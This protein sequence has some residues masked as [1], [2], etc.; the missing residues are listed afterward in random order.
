MITDKP[1]GE[2]AGHRVSTVRYDELAV[3]IYDNRELMGRAT[4]TM[5]CERIN[6]LF[7]QQGFVNIIFAAAPS[8]NEFLA[9]LCNNT[10]ADWRRVNAFHMDEYTGLPK[11]APQAFGSFLKAKIFGRLPF[12]SINYLNGNAPDTDAECKR[13]AALLAAFPPDIVCMGVG[14]NGHIAF[15]DPH[16]ADFN[17]AV[18]VKP[19]SLDQ[20]CRQ[21]QVNDGCFTGLDKVPTHALTLTIPALMAGKFIY[22]I[23]PGEK[24][25]NAVYN[26]LHKDII[27]EYPSTILRTHPNAVLFLDKDSGALL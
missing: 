8:Q 17:D 15:N 13:Y 7:A 1:R 11:D 22:C 19:V 16:V 26:T 14:E 20:P 5:V 24:K 18:M 21:Q 2:D 12:H 6:R 3:R 9:A 27:E 10:T 23:V 4:A 25:A